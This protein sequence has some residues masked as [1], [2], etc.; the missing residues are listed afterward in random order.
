MV[1]STG[2][3]ILSIT[4]VHSPLAYGTT[5]RLIIM[6]FNT[7]VFKSK[8]IDSKYATVGDVKQGVK[9]HLIRLGIFIFILLNNKENT[10]D[11]PDFMWYIFLIFVCGLLL[12]NLYQ[13][14]YIKWF[15][16]MRAN[17]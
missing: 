16:K 8:L 7:H 11:F 10:T 5:L 9:I 4:A 1:A 14:L 17:Y 3:F 12:F 13:L 15:V 6:K 2:E